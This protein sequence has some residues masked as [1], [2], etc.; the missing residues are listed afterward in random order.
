METNSLALAYFQVRLLLVSGRVSQLQLAI[1]LI[2]VIHLTRQP[3]HGGWSDLEVYVPSG[4]LYICIYMYI[5]LG[6]LDLLEVVVKNTNI[7]YSPN[8]G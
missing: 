3:L 4:A 7:S 8:G 6:Y 1:R 2:L 5:I